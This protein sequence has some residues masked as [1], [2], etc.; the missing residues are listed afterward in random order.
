VV[1]SGEKLITRI[2]FPRSCAKAR[3]SAGFDTLQRSALNSLQCND[4]TMGRPRRISDRNPNRIPGAKP[5]GFFQ[6]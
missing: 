4:L 1:E 2:P 5:P 3:I 6:G